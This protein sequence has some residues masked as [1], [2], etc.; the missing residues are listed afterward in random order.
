MA[1][2]AHKS[3][4]FNPSAP[5]SNPDLSEKAEVNVPG[6]AP[7]RAHDLLNRTLQCRRKSNQYCYRI[8]VERKNN[9]GTAARI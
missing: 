3:T 9:L 5:Q 7:V 1:Q 2:K 6:Q 8:D 4:Q